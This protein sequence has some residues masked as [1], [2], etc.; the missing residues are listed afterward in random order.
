MRIHGISTEMLKGQPAI[1]EVLPVFHRFCEH[2]VLVAHNAAFDILMLKINEAVTGV[3]FTHPVLDTLLLSDALHP[4][5]GIHD[6]EAIA[7][8]LGIRVVGR[9]TALGDAL[10]TAEIL[11]KMIPLLASK[12]VLTLKDALAISRRS[13][14]ARLRY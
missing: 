14:Y 7:Q 5:H 13:N 4:A 9:H 2:T 3:K 8:R 10:T 1:A 11:L 12:G 6:L